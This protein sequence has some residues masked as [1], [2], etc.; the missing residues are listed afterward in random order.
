LPGDRSEKGK[1]GQSEKGKGEKKGISDKGKVKREKR[2]RRLDPL[3]N[4]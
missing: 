1:K 3:K 2:K 4:D